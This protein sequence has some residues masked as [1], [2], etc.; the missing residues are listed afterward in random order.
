MVGIPDLKHF[1]TVRYQ[2]ILYR[3]KSAVQNIYGVVMARRS[4]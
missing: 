4:R 2:I 3:R 1:E